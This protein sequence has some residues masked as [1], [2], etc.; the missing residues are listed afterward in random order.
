MQKPEKKKKK[1]S[2]PAE[3]EEIK[4]R[5]RRHWVE[6][7]DDDGDTAADGEAAPTPDPPRPSIIDE[8]RER[9]EQ[10]EQKLQEYIEAFKSFRQEQ[11]QVRGRLKRDIDRRVELQFGGLVEQLL[12]TVDHLTLALS[13]V[14]DVPDAKPL[15]DGVRLALDGFLATLDRAGVERVTPDGETFDPNIAEALRL[16][17][18]TDPERDG[19]VT[20]T[21][22]AGYRLGDTL[23][24]PARVAVGRLQKGGG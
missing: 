23:I 10:A 2:P 9:T 15:A 24:R 1:D 8:Y 6:G 14:A 21:M 19:R 16:D 5:D 12:E 4:V 13:H 11:E 3:E 17:P 20:E 7:N 22:Q 18:V